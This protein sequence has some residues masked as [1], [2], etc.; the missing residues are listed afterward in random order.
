MLSAVFP[1]D[2]PGDEPPDQPPERVSGGAHQPP[3]RVS[4]GARSTKAANR[5]IKF[6]ASAT[7]QKRRSDADLR[8]QG[9]LVPRGPGRP[10][11]VDPKAATL[12]K[13]KQ[14]K[15]T[16]DRIAL[17]KLLWENPGCASIIKSGLKTRKHSALLPD[18]PIMEVL[19]KVLR[20]TPALED[21]KLH[22]TRTRTS[23]DPVIGCA[24]RGRL[25]LSLTCNLSESVEGVSVS[26]YAT[27]FSN[28]VQ[29]VVTPGYVRKQKSL[30]RKQKSFLDILSRISPSLSKI[31]VC[32][33]EA[34]LY[35]AFFKRHTVIFSGSDSETRHLTYSLFQFEILLYSSF[36]SMLRR[37]LTERPPT[38]KNSFERSL[39]AAW[40][41]AQEPG[42]DEDTEFQ[43]RHD[44]NGKVH[45]AAS[46]QGRRQPGA[47]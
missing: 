6:F 31:I 32:N 35:V 4:G 23:E 8:K 12:M 45:P 43:S 34:D 10:K 36:P 25:A 44:E 28:A 37:G 9:L 7:H 21:D 41:S 27:N 26:K 22:K 24:L 14:R 5:P 42:F 11:H 3:E 39:Q 20:K 18:N 47:D 2:H 40:D 15:A 29:G 19:N 33:V 13:R 30:F 16:K 46:C 17:D 38:G 1:P